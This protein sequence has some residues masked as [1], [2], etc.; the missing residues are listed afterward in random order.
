MKIVLAL[1]IAL[2]STFAHDYV[3]GYSEIVPPAGM[4]TVGSTHGEIAVD[5]AGLIYVS[6]NGGDKAGVQIYAPDG[7][8]LRNLAGAPNDLHG[9]VIHTEGERQFLYGSRLIGMSIV[10]VSL[11]G[12][13]IMTVDCKVIP[14]MYKN[15]KKA[16]KLTSVDVAPNG[17]M[18]VVDGYGLDY[19]HRFDKTGKYIGTFGGRK[20]PWNLSNCHKIFMDLR[21]E[22]P[23]ILCCD[24]KNGRLLHLDLDGGVVGVYAENLRRPS[25]VDFYNGQVAVAE[26]YGRVTILGKDGKVVKTVSDNEKIK[27]GNNWPVDVWKKGLVIT[28]HGIC[29]DKNGNILVSEFNK[30]GRIVRYDVKK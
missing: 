29:F 11:D 4:K 21:Y 13:L 24:R 26:I 14:D 3:P 10:K 28:P 16:L 22:K 5:A 12:K 25:G 8:Y 17:D 27:G 18:Y 7:K 1:L 23:R 6:V 15:K 20:A 30:F 2:S 19:I 9:F